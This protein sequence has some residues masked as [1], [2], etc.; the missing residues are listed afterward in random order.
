MTRE[1][2]LETLKKQLPDERR[3]ELIPRRLEK[4]EKASSKKEKESWIEASSDTLLTDSKP[5]LLWGQSGNG[6]TTWLLTCA[7]ELLS[8]ASSDWI[9]I[10][11]HCNQIPDNVMEAP[12]Q[13]LKKVLEQCYEEAFNLNSINV[14]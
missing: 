6:K 12:E 14:L 8:N 5:I 7:I 2:Y 13:W 9:P 1:S 4:L 11:R 10:F 3:V